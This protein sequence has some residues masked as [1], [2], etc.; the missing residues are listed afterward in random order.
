M[1]VFDYANPLLDAV[2]Q[3]AFGFL[4]AGAQI[5]IWALIGSV[6][7]MF[8][9]KVVSAQ[10][11]I[12]V[13]KQEAKQARAVLNAYDGDPDGLL[14]LV[15]ASLGA[16]FK[17]LGLTLWPAVVASIPILFL[18]GWLNLNYSYH[19]PSEGDL[20]NLTVY[21]AGEEL[22][23]ATMVR[24]DESHYTLS[25][26]GTAQSLQDAYGVTLGTLPA[27]LS[28]P[29]IHKRDW[30]AALFSN[31]L[32]YIPDEAAVD[33]VEIELTPIN[34]LGFGPSWLGGWEMI[35]FVLLIGASLTIKIVFKVN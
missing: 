3:S 6:L 7:T 11:K 25:W 32:G 34:H 19:T 8:L 21:P 20:L 35:F 14:P 33:A 31:P 17:H 15:R 12:A 22:T 27:D 4:P 23:G 9:Y 5:A 13:V 10:D 28:F 18:L 2:T 16:S 30:F 26:D 24:T 29:V 1:G